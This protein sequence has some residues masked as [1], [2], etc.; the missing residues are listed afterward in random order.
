M[1][2]SLEKRSH[3]IITPVHIITCTMKKDTNLIARI[4]ETGRT[5]GNNDYAKGKKKSG[6]L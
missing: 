5:R 6:L 3:G 2:R 4:S 1:E